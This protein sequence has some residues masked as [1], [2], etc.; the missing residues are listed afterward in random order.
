MGS[1]IYRI[2]NRKWVAVLV[3]VFLMCGA[4]PLS[5]EAQTQEY[6]FLIDTSDSMRTGR[7]NLEGPLRVTLQKYASTIPVDGSSRIWVFTFD[8]GLKR[9]FFQ[10]V[11]QG[12]KDLDD[13]MVFLSTRKYEG[14]ATYVFQALAGVFEQVDKALGDG[15]PHEVMIHLFTDGEDTGSRESFSTNVQAF[16]GL[17]QKFGAQTSLYYHALKHKVPGDVARLIQ[18]SEGLYLIPDIGMPPKARFDWR[19][20]EPTDS[21]P[22]TFIDQSVG[23]PERWQ[24]DFGDKTSSTEK[25]P[26]HLFKEIG[27]FRVEL[28]SVNAS[29]SNTVAKVIRVKGGPPK[30]KFALKDPDKP[31]YMGEPVLFEDQSTGKVTSWSWDFGDGQGESKD[32][33][34]RHT[35]QQAGTFKVTLKVAG[36]HGNDTSA[37]F[38]KVSLPETVAF[39]FFPKT[40]KHGQEVKFSN[41]SVG[42][43]K[44][45][46][47]DFGDG[48]RSDERAPTHVFGKVGSY[49]VSLTAETVAGRKAAA[50]K[51]IEVVSAFEPPVAKFTLATAKVEVGRVVTLNDDSKGSVTAWQ[52]DLGDGP[53]LQDRNVRHVFTKAGS[54]A[55]TLTVTGPV[56]K[57]QAKA[58]LEVVEPQWRIGVSPTPVAL[59]RAAS[60]AVEGAPSHVAS[61]VWDFGDKT[62]PVRQERAGLAQHT[63]QSEGKF[64]VTATI[65]LQDGEGAVR[66]ERILRAETTVC[67]ENVKVNLQAGG[68]RVAVVPGVEG[69]RK[70]R[71]PI[72]LKI[73]FEDKST[74]LIATRAWDFGD[75]GQSDDVSVSRT[76][77]SKGLYRVRLTVTDHFGRK[78]TCTESETVLIEAIGWR[79]PKP[80]RWPAT[81]IFFVL[82][83][84]LW[85]FLPCQLRRISHECGGARKTHRNWTK[86]LTV[87]NGDASVTIK[88]RRNWWLR[89][90]YIPV[91]HGAVEWTNAKG[92]KPN[93]P[94]LQTRDQLKLGDQTYIL[95]SLN[96]GSI[97]GGRSLGLLLL[98]TA[99]VVWQ[100]WNLFF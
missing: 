17:R 24:W 42:E 1:T 43:Y 58:T 10:R 92:E 50:E 60:F 4:L 97:T 56:G 87:R 30:A 73:R 48:G 51:I 18:P 79:P 69:A 22:V 46:R 96:H 8:Q 13:A 54:Y 89:K 32:R 66:V 35:Y 23:I 5:A 70:L 36:P 74:G 7:N 11:L 72:P 98:L 99:L 61:V 2:G 19:P 65:T 100:S 34:P 40:P 45:W 53:A 80:W 76:Y 44:T 95:R 77:S 55:V 68:D 52:W 21:A 67:G 39:S 16:K 64:N 27:E 93:R 41:D 85:R 26:T 62:G 57:D 28:T 71:G 47:W 90:R 29:G 15:Q 83:V 25:N 6:I 38:I 75:S 82:G 49:K 20:S 37:Q 84:L 94:Y 14:S 81:G 12:E 59:G 78:H 31:Q 91:M 63:Y 33:K 86:D 88:L 3:W 9:E